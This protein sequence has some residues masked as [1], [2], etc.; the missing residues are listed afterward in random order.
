MSSSNHGYKFLHIDKIGDGSASFRI[1]ICFLVSFIFSYLLMSCQYI[2][3]VSLFFMFLTRRYQ[4]LA[5]YLHA[6]SADKSYEA[7]LWRT[8]A[9][10]RFIANTQLYN[11][12]TELKKGIY[13]PTLMHLN[14]CCFFFYTVFSEALGNV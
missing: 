7:H 12:H 11:I 13:R 4:N 10:Y 2:N 3:V 14:I 8:G 5:A 1:C 6:S 9:R